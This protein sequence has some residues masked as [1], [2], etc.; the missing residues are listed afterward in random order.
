MQPRVETLS[1]QMRLEEALQA[2]SQ[3]THRT[4]PVLETG[5]LVGILSQKD[6]A[7][8]TARGLTG[9]HLVRDLMTANPVT[10]AP[11]DTLAYVLHLLD[12]HRLH[13]LPVVEGRRLVGILTRSDM[14]RIE[15]AH[16]N[17]EG[18]ISAPLERSCIVYQTRSPE[19]GQGRI[20]VPLSNPKTAAALLEIAV[21]I[22]RDRNSEIECLQVIVVP[23][24]QSLVEATV[25][26]GSESEITE[27]GGAARSSV[28]DSRSYS[29]S[30]RP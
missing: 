22:A 12:R 23:K 20:L 14:I 19:T 18:L 4:F 5:K 6:I 30:G 9:E 17:H 1:S 2:F 11:E 26:N 10:I 25:Q 16:L 15:A 27:A 24:H 7:S 21:A 13:S 3:S 28:A 8:L 29:D